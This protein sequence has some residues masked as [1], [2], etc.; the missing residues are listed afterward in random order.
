MRPVLDALCQGVVCG[1][2]RP[3]CLV[4]HGTVFGQSSALGRG[5]GGAF[6]PITYGHARQHRDPH[7]S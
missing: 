5:S 7:T 2:S 4:I 1:L 6:P 3:V